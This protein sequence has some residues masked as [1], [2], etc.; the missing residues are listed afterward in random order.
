MEKHALI[1]C[2]SQYADVR[3]TG[4]YDVIFDDLPEVSQDK[5][6]VEAGL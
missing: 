1:V 4:A 2:N 6:N 5:V 3:Q